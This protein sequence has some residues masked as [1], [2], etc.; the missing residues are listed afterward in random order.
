MEEK[1]EKKPSGY[2]KVKENCRIEALKCETIGEFK[3]K[4]GRA[5]KS[6]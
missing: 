4:S 1:K 5:Y 3:Q 2:W 6:S